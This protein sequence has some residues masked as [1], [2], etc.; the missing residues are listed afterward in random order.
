MPCWCD[1]GGRART[2]SSR[3]APTASARCVMPALLETNDGLRRA[4]RHR[5]R[6]ARRDRHCLP[7]LHRR[8]P[9]RRVAGRGAHADAARQRLR[10]PALRQPDLVGRDREG[11]AGAGGGAALLQCTRE[12]VRVHLHAERHR[13]DPAGRR[14]VSVRHGSS[15]PPT[16]TTRSTASG[17]SPAQGAPRRRTCRSRR[18]TCA[19]TSSRITSAR[20]TAPASS[21]IPRSP[22]SR[23]SSIRWS[24][25]TW[26]MSVAGTC[27]WTAPRSRRRA[28][29]TCRCGSRTS[30]RSPSTRCS[31]TRRAWAR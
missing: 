11:G 3:S 6:T 22:T 16:T 9:L 7:R 13:R 5:V 10:Q 8:Q 14:G 27:S 30:S 18:P 29:S 1:A 23:A 15:P 25:S 19:W 20:P 24:G 26:P 12:R 17:S 31:A 28:G 4:P 2:R 21:P